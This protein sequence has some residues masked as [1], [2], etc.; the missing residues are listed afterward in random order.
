MFKNPFTIRIAIIPFEKKSANVMT[1]ELFFIVKARLHSVEP[2]L[3]YTPWCLTRP[4]EL[5]VT[6]GAVNE[7][8]I[9][10]FIC[11]LMTNRAYMICWTYAT[12]VLRF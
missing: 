6:L 2:A 1:V 10:I 7:G 4:A 11:K 5:L 9:T 8:L 3:I 12:F